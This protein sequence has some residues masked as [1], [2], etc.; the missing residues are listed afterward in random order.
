MR[1]APCLHKE[2]QGCLGWSLEASSYSCPSV[3][4]FGCLL[5]V[6]RGLPLSVRDVQKMK[7][8]RIWKR[9]TQNLHFPCS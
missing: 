8:N 3:L 5:Y 1:G 6:M 2:G 9:A 7:W 4:S